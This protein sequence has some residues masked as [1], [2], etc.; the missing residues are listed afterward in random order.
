MG[1]ESTRQ[2]PELCLRATIAPVGVVARRALARGV[3]TIYEIHH[4]TGNGCLVYEEG[5]QLG[6]GPSRVHGALAFS[7]R[8]PVTDALEVFQ[9]DTAFGV[10]S[11]V[12]DA[13][14]D[15]VVDVGTET[16]L[17]S[18]KL[19]EMTLGTLCAS[20]L[21]AV[22]KS[23]H[24]LAHSFRFITGVRFPIGVGSQ[25]ADAEVYSEPVSGVNRRTIGDLN[26]NIQ[27]PLTLAKHEIGLSAHT[28]EPSPMV[29]SGYEGHED[30]SSEREQRH[31][32][33]GLKGHN[34]LV[35]GH[36]AV[37]LE[38]RPLAPVSLVRLA[39]LGD[40]AHRHLRRESESVPQV[41]V[42]EMVKTDLVPG[43]VLEGALCQPLA[44]LVDSLHGGEQVRR[45]F[46]CGE[47]LGNRNQFHTLECSTPR[48]TCQSEKGAA[49]LPAKAGSFRA[50]AIMSKILETKAMEDLRKIITPTQV[51]T[52][53]M[54][55]TR[56]IMRAS[57]MRPQTIL[58]G[59]GAVTEDELKRRMTWCVEMAL[60]LYKDKGWLIERI[61]DWMPGALIMHLDGS[62]PLVSERNAWVGN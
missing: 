42:V 24:P 45:L 5:T 41:P 51:N 19:F 10:F 22:A 16:G 30:A 39:D 23:L 57:M 4:N 54:G 60:Q 29:W 62:D 13:F 59:A 49:L 26:R 11:F 20:G 52:L 53:A 7:D 40:S 37:Q 43:S 35:V 25:I 32:V 55:L 50:E 17:V 12:D 21:E 31:T 8:Y 2:A 9:G 18:R 38:V 28:F 15:D 14:R 47:Q 33:H 36:T 44:S 56:A 61:V 1:S 27:V 58:V 48:T 46:G 34:A 6:E 3:A